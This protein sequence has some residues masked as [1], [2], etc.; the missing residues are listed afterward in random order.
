MNGTDRP[1]SEEQ[2][3]WFK[4]SPTNGTQSELENAYQYYAN[5]SMEEQYTSGKNYHDWKFRI[6]FEQQK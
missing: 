1:R 2:L 3:F 5:A 6:K 4:Y